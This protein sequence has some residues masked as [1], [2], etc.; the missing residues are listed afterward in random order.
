MELLMTADPTQMVILAGL[1]VA[2]GGGAGILFP[3]RFG[4]WLSILLTAAGSLLGLTGGVMHLAGVEGAVRELAWSFPIESP[5]VRIDPL[6]AFF[7]IPLFIVAPFA[8]LFG[9]GYRPLETD[10]R[11]GTLTLFL[12]LFSGSMVFLLISAHAILFLMMWEIMAV[13]AWFLLTM[14]SQ[15][16][17]VRRAGMIYLFATHGGTMALFVMFSLIRGATGTF[18]FPLPGEMGA[19]GGVATAILILALVGFGGKAGVMPL[20]FWLPGAHANAPSH[21]SAMMSGV[22]LKMGVYGILRVSGFFSTLP[23]WFGWLVLLLGGW[24]AVSGIALAASQS[25]LKRLFACSSIENMGIILTGIGIGFIGMS[26]GDQTLMALGFTGGF[27]HILNHALFKPLL[28]LGSG[29]IIHGTHTRQIDRLGGLLKSMPWTGNAMLLGA[30]AISGLPPLNGF[31]GEFFLY[32][33][34]FRHAMTSSLPFLLLVAPM[35]ALVGGT[36]VIAFV[37]FFGI[38]FLGSPRREDAQPHDGGVTM[39]GPMVILAI[40]ML[41]VALYP[42]LVIRG[43]MPV[44]AQ[45]GR[46]SLTGVSSLL[47]FVPATILG[48]MNLTVIV[49]AAGVSFVSRRFI[50]VGSPRSTTWGCGY[51]APTPRMQYTGTSFSQVAVDLFGIVATISRRAPRI[52]LIFPT[53][54]TFGARTREMVID[55]LLVPLFQITGSGFSWLRRLQ[56]GKLHIYMLYIFVTLF[57]M[58]LAGHP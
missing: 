34:S 50:P 27:I 39:T 23:P 12:S 40:L 51:P 55:A 49:A 54:E 4:Q 5:L 58:M 3:F 42:P 18:R 26:Q 52:S 53:L 44:V 1:I 45:V 25:D 15:D 47:S 41:L 35:L 16:H 7:L 19:E 33:A 21:V 20:H 46:I 6:S 36:A 57:I 29:V 11:R 32:L 2:C 56:H 48:W 10:P 24:S 14:D 22:M 9:R 13:S 31:I 43:A 28:F 30:A 38:V 17:Q 37:K 8:G